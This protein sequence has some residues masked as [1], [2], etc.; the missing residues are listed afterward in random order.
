MKM[1]PFLLRLFLFVLSFCTFRS[2]QAQFIACD[3]G[4]SVS[5]A[6]NTNPAG[7]TTYIVT[8]YFYSLDSSTIVSFDTSDYVLNWVIDGVSYA[9]D[10]P[11]LLTSVSGSTVPFT[12]VGTF[13]TGGAACSETFTGSVYLPNCSP[14]VCPTLWAPVCAGGITFTNSCEAECAGFMTYTLGECDTTPTL[15]CSAYFTTATTVAMEV[16]FTPMISSSDSTFTLT[17]TVN[18]TVMSSTVS[19]E[20]ILPAFDSTTTVCLSIATASGC[21]DTYC[22]AGGG[23]ICPAVWDPVCAGGITF[24]NSCEAECAGYFTY[25]MGI[26]DSTGACMTTIQALT[27]VDSSG[28]VSYSY[29]AVTS[30]GFATSY[31]WTLD[32]TIVSTSSTYSTTSPIVG[33]L[34][35]EILDSTGCVSSDCYYGDT[36]GVVVGVGIL[37]SLPG[38]GYIIII[39]TDTLCVSNTL[40][41]ET[42]V[43]SPTT[44][45]IVGDSV[46]ITYDTL[47]TGGGICD[48]T[49]ALNTIAPRLGSDISDDLISNF[50]VYPQPASDYVNFV[51]EANSSLNATSYQIFDLQGK[52]LY[53]RNIEI[54]KGMNK[55][56]VN[57]EQIPNGLY[58]LQ[59]QNQAIKLNI[60]H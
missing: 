30:S 32:S 33:M 51:F 29:S 17:W 37:D 14:C 36:T 22:Q 49:I 55:F 9:D 31:T 8:P 7:V 20:L 1:K 44:P 26:C 46:I 12:I 57:T 11:E 47:S 50:G 39:G 53:T 59:I 6:C 19:G 34:C 3:Y 21:T 16:I 43:M 18:G 60:V 10:A 15:S 48:V 2:V 28:T 40:V 5:A 27:S 4:V 42:A 25:T 56:Q 58:I 54:Q 45:V 35:V 41:V 23:C 52:M 38:G 24:A 13:Y